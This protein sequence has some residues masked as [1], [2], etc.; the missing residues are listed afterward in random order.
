MSQRNRSVGKSGRRIAGSLNAWLF[1]AGGIASLVIGVGANAAIFS[2]T[3]SLWLRGRGIAQPER[4]GA[5]YFRPVARTD[6]A[7][8]AS[9]TGSECQP[10]GLLE[11]ASVAFQVMVQSEASKWMAPRVILAGGE[12]VRATAVSHGYFHVLGVDLVGRDFSP[13]DDITDRGVAIVSHRFARQHF[14][15]DS[16]AVGH[17]MPL[18]QGRVTVL[19]VAP[20]EFEGA[21]VGEHTDVWIP[22]GAISTFSK[23]PQSVRNLVPLSPLVRLK[24]SGSWKGVQV[25]LDELSDG[26]AVVFSL[27]ELEYVPSSLGAVARQK[28][29]IE[30]LRLMAGLILAAACLNLSG[31]FVTRIGSKRQELAL[32]L[33]LGS[34]RWRLARVFEADAATLVFGGVLASLLAAYLV[35]QSIQHLSLPGGVSI[36]DLNPSVD[37]RVSAFAAVVAVATM[38]VAAAVP[39]HRALTTAPRGLLTGGTVGGSRE[40]TR[41]RHFIVGGYVAVAVV[42]TAGATSLVERMAAL[43]FRDQ[44]LEA[45]C[46]VVASITP[47]T[48]QYLAVSPEGAARVVADFR[49]ALE[50]VHSL[51]GVDDAT[52]GDAPLAGDGVVTPRGLKTASMSARLPVVVAR[53]GSRYVRVIGGQLVSGRDLRDE[54]TGSPPLEMDPRTFQK[55]AAPVGAIIDASLARTLWPAGDAVGRFLDVDHRQCVVVGVIRDLLPDLPGRIRASTVIVGTQPSGW[56][57]ASLPA[58]LVRKAAISNSAPTDVL[59]VVQSAFLSG[60]DVRARTLSQS[61]AEATAN[62]QL[63]ARLFA[64]SGTASSLLGMVGTYLLAVL[65][66]MSRRREFAV[67]V[68]VGAT[69]S[70]L[71]WRCLGRVIATVLAGTVIGLA[72]TFALSR[73]SLASTVGLGEMGPTSYLLSTLLVVFSGAAA[74]MAGTIDIRRIDVQRILNEN[75]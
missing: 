2:V 65:L 73:T 42:L 45:R 58:I 43:R 35:T 16:A 18:S 12:R 56:L 66:V 14:P 37:W 57:G 60:S 6:G 39:L 1:V 64:W 55:Q 38:I 71:R 51:P 26:K 22:L 24:P 3:T 41:S 28:E 59:R 15:S 31:L 53:G 29:L 68:A 7:L 34:S 40:A 52:Y 72:S 44:R 30:T 47:A 4:V 19:G 9:A 13:D 49:L 61:I 48:E 36:A 54:D 20:E 74:A 46:V 75:G 8:V 70:G 10:L 17:P 63:G 50:R 23:V 27:A 67:R 62:E 25:Q 21:R 11:Q 5:V 32:R 33:A 69:P